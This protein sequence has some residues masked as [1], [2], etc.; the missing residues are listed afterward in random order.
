MLLSAGIG[1]LFA[2]ASIFSRRAWARPFAAISGPL[3]GLAALALWAGGEDARANTEA[4]TVE[5]NSSSASTC[6]S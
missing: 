1:W 4:L 6:P 2:A 3:A 5:Q